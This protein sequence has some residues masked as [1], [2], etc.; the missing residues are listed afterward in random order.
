MVE[1]AILTCENFGEKSDKT[2]DFQC[3]EEPFGLLNGNSTLS[4]RAKAKFG[5]YQLYGQRPLPHSYLSSKGKYI[6]NEQR[7]NTPLAALYAER[8]SYYGNNNKIIYLA[9]A[10]VHGHTI[11]VRT[12]TRSF[13]FHVFFSHFSPHY[14]IFR[15]FFRRRCNFGFFFFFFCFTGFITNGV[16]DSVNW[17][18][19]LALAFL[20]CTNEWA[21]A[22]W[23]LRNSKFDW[24]T[25]D[26]AGPT[27]NWN[28]ET[29]VKR[30]KK[31]QSQRC[32]FFFHFLDFIECGPVDDTTDPLFHFKRCLAW[33][34]NFFVVAF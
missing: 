17:W 21:A 20:I 3:F 6:A 9:A 26:T 7:A 16:I 28:N 29:E 33:D 1:L 12:W 5:M 11:V 25:N 32:F 22:E 13:S 31:G 19:E 27:W 23:F 24:P 10:S 2:N 18:I 4:S 8:R 15:F 14:K 30:K 34:F